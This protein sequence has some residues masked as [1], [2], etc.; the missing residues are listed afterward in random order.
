MKPYG[1][2]LNGKLIATFTYRKNVINSFNRLVRINENRN[3]NFD[4]IAVVQLG[5]GIILQY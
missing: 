4:D 1:L 5:H 2:F 3:Q